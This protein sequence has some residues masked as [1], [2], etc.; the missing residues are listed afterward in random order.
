[1]NVG[2]NYL[3]EHVIQEARIPLCVS[4]CRRH[5]AECSTGP[6]QCAVHH[7]RPVYDQVKEITARIDDIARGAALMCGTQA[8]WRIESAYSDYIPNTVLAGVMS[9]A[10]KQIGAPA[11]DERGVRAGGQV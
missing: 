1:M 5:S 8:S 2:V 11:V 4:G 10:M 3:R 7:P 9:E 6:C